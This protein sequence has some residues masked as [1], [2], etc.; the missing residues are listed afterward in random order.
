[1]SATSSGRFNLLLRVV[2]AALGLATA[3]LMLQ[4]NPLAG[5]GFVVMGLWI[6][7]DLALQF[8]PRAKDGI[9]GRPG[10]FAWFLVMGLLMAGSGAMTLLGYGGR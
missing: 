9:P 7:F 2:A 5:L 8:R 1:M 10:L 3:W 4:K 6:V